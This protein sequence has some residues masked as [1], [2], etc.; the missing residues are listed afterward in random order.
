[1]PSK[2]E[3]LEAVLEFLRSSVDEMK[4]WA[5]EHEE[6]L[7]AVVLANTKRKKRFFSLVVVAEAMFY[8]TFLYGGKKELGELIGMSYESV[9]EWMVCAGDGSAIREAVAT[10]EKSNT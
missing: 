3:Q 9:R 2:E 8:L 4:A 7:L 10:Y 6:F 5:K 1:M